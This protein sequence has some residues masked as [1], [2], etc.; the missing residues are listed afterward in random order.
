MSAGTGISHSEYNASQTESVHFLQIWILPDETG[1]LP[2]YEQKA[3]PL[4]KSRGN[5]TLIASKDG[6]DGSVT[7]HQD[8]DVW[9]GRLSAGETVVFNLRPGRHAWSQMARG[10]VMLNG[11]VLRVG[12]GA[13]TSQEEILEVRAVEA[14]ELLMFDLA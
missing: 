2:G 4:D 9:T 3:F 6:R 14:A 11:N 10:S 5:R 12:D 13:A 7:V 1:L 8:V